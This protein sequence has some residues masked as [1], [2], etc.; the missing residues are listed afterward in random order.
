MAES[1]LFQGKAQIAHRITVA[2]FD[3]EGSLK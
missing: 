3:L 1:T 2:R